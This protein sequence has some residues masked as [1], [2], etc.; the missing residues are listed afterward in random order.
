MDGLAAGLEGAGV[1]VGSAAAGVG[2]VAFLFSGQGAQRGG[3]GLG[4]YEAYLV[5]RGALDEVCGRFDGLLGCSLLELVFAEPGSREAELLDQTRF[6]QPGL[7]A[8]EVALLALVESFGV[9]PDFLIG[10]SVGE[11]AAAYAA[12]VFSL[13]DACVLV[14][15]RGR[16]MSE[17]ARQGGAMLAVQA[18]EQELAEEL[19]GCGGA[20]ELA[21]VNAAG[22]VV[23]SGDERAVL[24][25]AGRWQGKGRK[26]RRLR[27]S[28]AFHSAHMDGMLEQFAGAIE[29]IAFQ[30]PRLSVISN[31]TG[32]PAGPEIATPRYWVR[33]V[34]ETVRFADGVRWL[35]QHGA[36][37]FIE[38]GPDG[39]LSAMVHQCL[40][41]A[42]TPAAGL[43]ETP[44]VR[45]PVIEPLLRADRSE[46]ETLLAAL[47]RLWV[48]GG[49]VDWSAFYDTKAT[50]RLELPTYAF[51]RERYW[52]ASPANTTNTKAIGQHH[53]EHPLLGAAVAL[54]DGNGWIFTGRIDT[55]QHPWLT[56]HQIHHTNPLP[57]TAHLEMAWYAGR[58]TGF[59][60]VRELTLQAPLMLPPGG[61]VQLQITVS[62]PD[63]GGAPQIAIYSRP[64]AGA[65]EEGVTAAGATEQGMTEVD[66]AA[67]EPGW[68][69]HAAGT[70][71]PEPSPAEQDEAEMR[72]WPPL[73]EPLNIE[74]LYDELA[75]LGLDYGPSFQGLHAAWRRDE[76]LFA[77]V[78]LGEQER[79][80]AGAFGLHPALLDAALHPI[81]A[82]QPA[83]T[84][85][86]AKLPF[87]WSGA[88]LSAAATGAATDTVRVR[89]A[90][91]GD[92][93]VAVSIA[94]RD[95]NEIARVGSL[96]S[97]AA[98]SLR[99]SA[100]RESL[101][102]I[103]WCPG[104]TTE[105]D[106][107]G[108]PAALPLL[109]AD[110]GALAHALREHGLAV[111]PSPAAEIDRL[112]AQ[113][114]SP[115]R[116]L[117]D[118]LYR[119]HACP[120]A[121]LPALV[122]A[123]VCDLTELLQRWLAAERPRGARLAIVTQNA[124][125]ASALD[126][127]GDREPAACLIGAAVWGLVR[128]AAVEGHERLMLIDVDGT[129][130]SW[131]AL[132][133]A[134][135]RD[136][137][138]LAIRD[139]ETFVPR[140]RRVADTDSPQA[141]REAR[142]GAATASRY[143]ADAQDA[144]S[145]TV[146]ITGGTGGLGAALARH[147]VADRGVRHLLLASRS[148]AQAPGAAGLIE[149]LAALGAE[150]DVR[151]C[152]VASRSQ[153]Q[154]LLEQ[155]PA[156]RPLRMVLH[157]AG[158]LEDGMLGSLTP[159]QIATVLAPKV[160]A[161]WHLHRL[162]GELGGCELIL[163]SSIAGVL[164]SAGQAGYA[165][166]NAFLDA[167]A[168]ERHAEGLPGVSIAWGPWGEE[169]GGMTSRLREADLNRMRRLGMEPLAVEQGLALFDSARGRQA[170]TPLVAAHLAIGALRVQARAGLLPVQMSELVGAAVL[171]KR[172]RD[173]GSL[174]DRLAAAPEQAR[175][176]IALD[177]VC[178]ETASVLGHADGQ[179]IDGRLGFTQ[180]GF[181]SLLAVE[182]RNRLAAAS[183]MQLPATLI[184]DHPSPAAVAQHLLERVAG[185]DI[186]TRS[187]AR[188]RRG[189]LDE[190]I[191]IVGMA[192]RY[193]GGVAS[194]QELWRLVADGGDAIGSFPEDR[195]WDL[196]R[197]YDPDPDHAGTSYARDGGFLYD[198]AEFDAGLFGISPREAQA[199]DPQQRLLLESCWEAIEHAGI[200]PLSL[201]GSPTGVFAG[202]MYHDYGARVNG[203][204]PAD[205]EAYIGIGSAGSVFSGRVA[206]TFG[207][208][209]P[210]VTVDTACSSS[211]VALHWACQALR[212]GE[213]SLALAG[214]ATVMS[215]PSVFVEF[216][217]QRGLAVDG[218]CKSFG[219][220]ADG[221][222]WGEGVGVLLV[223]RL[224][225]ALRV[226]RRVLG[227][228]RGSAVNQDGASNGLTAPN[229]PSQRRVIEQALVNAG[230]GVDGVD[231]VEGHGTG[232][233]LG[234][235]IE[236]QAILETY[237]RGR[238]GGD[239]LWL[240]SV[241]SNIGHAQAAA[242][243]AG[244]IKMVMAMRH[245][246]LPRSL[247]LGE[248]SRKVD[249]SQGAVS[250]LVEEVPWRVSG[251]PR[252]AGVS[253]FG[254]SG[255][256]A[257][258]ILEEPPADAGAG[259]FAGVAGSAGG[260]EI[261]SGA[262]AVADA[263]AGG[264]GS[265]VGGSVGGVVPWVL[266]GVG[267]DGL[268]GQARRLAGWLDDRGLVG[269]GDVGVA[270]AG[271]AGLERRAVLFGG[272]RDGLVEGVD[273]LA[274]GLEGA[275]VVVGSAAA[276][277]GGVAFL[278]SGQGAQRGG[279]GLGLYEAYLVFRGALD[280]V[281]GRFDGLLGCSLL[282][283]VFAEPGSREAELL[284]QT[285]FAQPGLFALEVALL[286]LVE[287]FGVHPDFLIGHSVGEIAAAYAAGVF[288][289]EDACVLVAARGR[290][291]SELARQGGAMLAVQASEQE[292]AEELEGC[293]GAVELAAVNAAGSVVL[294]GDERA[295]LE[296]AGRWQGKG[297]K[298]RRLRVSHA[299][300]SAHMD[301]MLE[302]FAGAIES[303]A[304]Q[305]PRLSVISNLTGEPAG[306]EIATPRYWVRHVRETVRFADGVRWLSQHGATG[307]IELGPDGP[308]SAMVHQCLTE[309]DTPAAGLPETPAVRQ[310][311]IEPLLRADR[312][313]PETLLA[314]LAR[315]WVAGGTVNWS[316]FYDTKA[317]SRLELPTYAFQ[318]ERYWL[319]SP[320]NTTNTKAIGQHHTEHPLLGAAVAL[321][322][323]NGWIFTG[324]IDT[325]Q[326]P[327][328]TH[329]QIHH[330]N[331]LPATA[332]L[333]MALHVADRLG[334]G[335]LEQLTLHAPLMLGEQPTQIQVHVAEPD[336][337][338]RAA[339]TV[340]SDSQHPDAELRDRAWV[341]NASG[342]LASA[343][344]DGEW[345]A[346][347]DPLRSW[348]PPD[349]VMLDVERHYEQLDALGFEYGPEFRCMRRAWQAGEDVLVE[350][351][352][353]PDTAESTGSFLLHPAL[354]D[355]A[356]HAV[357]AVLGEGE[358]GSLR[359]PTSIE[360]V[361]AHARGARSLRVRVSAD[362]ESAISLQAFDE[363]GSLV[364]EIGSLVLLPARR[365]QL[366]DAG[367][368]DSLL[369]LEWSSI[370]HG[371]QPAS[372]GGAW[373]AI[374]AG[375]EPPV[376]AASTYA[377]VD[378]LADALAAGASAPEALLIA[379]GDSALIESEPAP[380]A[381]GLDPAAAHT[382]VASVLALLQRWLAEERLL[383]TRLV[384]MTREAVA[385]GE[386]EPVRGLRDAA[387]WGLL[388][389][390]Q[391]ES[392]G[393]ILLLDLDRRDCPPELISAALASGEPQ[394]ALR[395][396]RLLAPRLERSPSPSPS[397]AQAAGGSDSRDAR[398]EGDGLGGLGERTVLITG[399]TGGIGAVLAKH[400]LERHGARSLLLVSRR[401]IEA[402]GAAALKAQLESLGASVSV[403]ACDLGDRAQV[404]Q[405]LGSIPQER[406][407]GAV[408]H[409]AGVLDDGVI[410]SLTADRVANVL[411]PKLDGA[412]HLHELTCE[413]ELSAFVLFSS[414][415]GTLGTPGQGA[416]AAANAF[417]DAL[418]SHRSAR[419][420]PATS[421]AWGLWELGESGMGA[422]L[423]ASDRAR[424]QRGGVRPMP[425]SEALLALRPRA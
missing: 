215:T 135:E 184:F 97:R 121:D 239:P 228:V 410:D 190:P 216:S 123:S 276:G 225:D 365:E 400:L 406:P 41:E 99:E 207:F 69:L 291:M 151:A 46:P 124:V 60:L 62:D 386:R 391:S 317:T 204:A 342:V 318:R 32:E 157:A 337:A 136:E 237:G 144:G 67:A 257:H 351:A 150:V 220:G 338:G 304:F 227:V 287:S 11:I 47:A 339:I 52:L 288:S 88:R 424:L 114:A 164:G 419:G 115:D 347:A 350:V 248:P 158:V 309:A 71:A 179:A 378:A 119:Q 94:D 376:A 226:G 108:A 302:Q 214:G 166:A 57:A 154:L 1:V 35:S 82:L 219:E 322:D 195:G 23:L 59:P 370:A 408:V 33:H 418:A 256:N 355:S 167:L 393:R 172:D 38:L 65:I 176:R 72:Q 197:L 3:M 359:L 127:A 396:G 301:G 81:V 371:R 250:L 416:Y 344:Q 284:D 260:A 357:A 374:A 346:H 292:L 412:L 314:A 4:L 134:L 409:A 382:A 152:D 162:T 54:A 411:R 407:L 147:L 50:S 132:R 283:L 361:S 278:F 238:G 180:L 45:Q 28:H 30:S 210:A 356:L 31:L 107:G 282:E 9:H 153:L 116:V 247:H 200:D 109:G 139:G 360:R 198:A 110:D 243:V 73:A 212:A 95:G 289:L 341:C 321:A 137:S 235:P 7:F 89:L 328:L 363:S 394:L 333:E 325:Q 16:L 55:Q 128:A 90:P 286:A 323:G 113:A 311:V 353:D 364:V 262:V 224:S 209:G 414:A 48:A 252:R 126:R 171:R 387:V 101:F 213:C 384:V 395:D 244:V 315:L 330:T 229:G 354:L 122:R 77:E 21:A 312:S 307:F 53:T 205:I 306:P 159:E 259:G 280:E 70:L 173:R 177:L 399:G 68:T 234:D 130:S 18:S 6:A 401:G 253:S 290:L 324:R 106:P 422:G 37:G 161:A 112:L 141:S 40:T 368:R 133:G 232:T 217:R 334:F 274:A 383:Q 10:H 402:D 75:A 379:C 294:S 381:Q 183:G 63:R 245:G 74:E 34:R 188:R 425:A 222:G 249:W 275:G 125:R 79:A 264:G 285:R 64:E 326:H 8:L 56:H 241:K 111:L 293:G 174:A 265:V 345:P 102:T 189:E 303:I 83:Q 236:A 86:T 169:A 405:L 298:T 272:G 118:C 117:V 261:S 231:V 389:S 417:L 140:L 42:D 27:V 2:G 251:R 44:A 25:L 211:L 348:P 165:A 297:R 51:Q 22:S 129:P 415:S 295:V 181:D 201:E 377:S 142:P 352:L 13:E 277:V 156:Q 380:S 319:A 343:A 221:V 420:L 300:H 29:S 240:G 145:G 233:E 26:T 358:P 388:R 281:C 327:W 76:E 296:L 329:H 80:H 320:A 246:V 332:H 305:S 170:S 39:P 61:A 193:P 310:P 340:S 349:A 100:A 148:G 192:C 85:R 223:E 335:A 78:T 178:A 397:P 163:F 84:P 373:A 413:L 14:A 375:H 66:A 199:I 98:S 24:E 5:F 398:S 362:G 390:A 17:L 230:V 12:G 206:Y 155:I 392:P 19:E 175:L 254:I 268:R 168:I 271:R 36:T 263:G 194:P 202:V 367:W 423:A 91:A 385:A 316:A 49:T 203:S 104:P 269:V 120:E 15:A 131:R 191:A 96:V 372:T 258:V 273:G 43:P 404:A 299:F 403:A 186:S 58:Y 308:L 421:L 336:A 92:D 208:Q 20:V 242:G 255:T 279:M 160:D 143:E 103:A 266:S 218:R 182:L 196:D 146:L 138:Q 267:G 185:E 366:V 93:A 149:E 313:E 331:P 87:S 105:A 187:P 270:L 369:R